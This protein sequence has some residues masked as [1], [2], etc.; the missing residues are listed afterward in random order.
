M[1]PTP[2]RCWPWQT[3]TCT[4]RSARG[5]TGSS[6]GRALPPA[7]SD[8]SLTGPGGANALTREVQA[9]GLARFVPRLALSRLERAVASAVHRLRPGHAE[10]GQR[11][12]DLLLDR[13]IRR[14]R[15]GGQQRLA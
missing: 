2:T 10:L 9:V 15:Q 5:G 1:G 11:G 3:R 14:E 12:E 6:P 7:A 8:R 4:G 13:S